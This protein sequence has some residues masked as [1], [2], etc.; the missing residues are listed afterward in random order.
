MP[1]AAGVLALD[2]SLAKENMIARS[3]WGV[4]IMEYFGQCF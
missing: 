3:L 2:F 4:P 1:I